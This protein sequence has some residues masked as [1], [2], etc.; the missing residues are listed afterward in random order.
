[1]FTSYAAAN[2]LVMGV[3]SPIDYEVK[4]VVEAV[5]LI[6]STST[7]TY[8]NPFV[9]YLIWHIEILYTDN[10]GRNSCKS[11]DEE[12]KWSGCTGR[13]GINPLLWEYDKAIQ[14]QWLL[15][16]ENGDKLWLRDRKLSEW[17]LSNGSMYYRGKVS[18]GSHPSQLKFLK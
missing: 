12:Q 14:Q 6:L 13:N 15:D 16:W 2:W 8:R 5:I 7:L 10:T 4:R 17:A 18:I 11:E 1:M 3:T 9:L